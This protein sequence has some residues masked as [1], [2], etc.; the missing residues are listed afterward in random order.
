MFTSITA[1]SIR[2][3]PFTE[4]LFGPRHD[5]GSEDAKMTCGSHLQGLNVEG[6]TEIEMQSKVCCA[7]QTTNKP[8]LLG[9]KKTI[10]SRA[11]KGRVQEKMRF[12][13]GLA[14]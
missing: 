3:A 4:Y 11:G 8:R 2:H 10:S 1:G 14:Q 9:K 12:G 7:R 5:V 6:T 13:L